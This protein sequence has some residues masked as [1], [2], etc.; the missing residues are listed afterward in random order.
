MIA[1]CLSLLLCTC[2]ALPSLALDRPAKL[3][4]KVKKMVE[5]LVDLSNR[6][7]APGVDQVIAELKGEK[8]SCVL[9]A[10]AFGA[11]DRPEHVQ[12][13][14]ARAMV[15]LKCPDV[16]ALALKVLGD[17]DKENRGAFAVIFART[18]D[19]E[20]TAPTAALAGSSRPFDKEMACDALQLLGDKA[21]IPALVKATQDS[22]FSVR[23]K[24]AA[25]LAS[26][27]S[28]EAREALCR[29][30]TADS[31]IGVQQKA[32]ESLGTLADIQSVPC[33]I[34]VLRG[35]PGA[36][37]LAAHAALQKVTGMDLGTDASAWDSWW[38]KY[39][40]DHKPRK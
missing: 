4:S 22:F 11:P 16:R 15:D 6:K 36:A 3:D 29:L 30:A 17:V 40:K 39:K 38:E 25:A 26:F 19:N 28:P 37:T 8:A 1:R 20:L 14:I 23:Q 33:L 2:I 31:N 34:D 12:L 24:A 32:M 9:L 10:E 35:R 27:P 21:G 18:K 5:N 13:D 7:D